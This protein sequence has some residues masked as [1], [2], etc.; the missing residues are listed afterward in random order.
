MSITGKLITESLA[1]DGGREVTVYVPP[2]PP[3][4]V[5]FAGDGQ[6]I[7]EWG[8][9]LEAPEGVPPTMIV[10]VHTVWMM[11]RR[12]PRVLTGL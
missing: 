12:G 11:K 9:V 4:A 3:E 5:V 7:S 1:Y 2:E 6:L 10:G 8:D